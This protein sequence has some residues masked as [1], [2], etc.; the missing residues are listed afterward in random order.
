LRKKLVI[1]P[2]RSQK[3][4]IIPSQTTLTGRG[5]GMVVLVKISRNR[6]GLNLGG[7]V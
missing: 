1:G 3:H 6:M 7:L 2:V 5:E 4:L